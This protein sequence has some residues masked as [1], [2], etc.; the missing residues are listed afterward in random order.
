MVLTGVQPPLAQRIASL[1][2]DLGDILTLGTLESGIAYAL[3][4]P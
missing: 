2:E 1:G 3:R 4:A